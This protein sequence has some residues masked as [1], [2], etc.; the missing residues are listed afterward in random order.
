MTLLVAEGG[1]RGLAQPAKPKGTPVRP[2]MPSGPG[3]GPGVS[4][5]PTPRPS[6]SPS[7]PFPDA[8]APRHLSLPDPTPIVRRFDV[9]VAFQLTRTRTMGFGPSSIT[10]SYR[11]AWVLELNGSGMMNLRSRRASVPVFAAGP[12]T[13]SVI[14]TGMPRFLLISDRDV[15]RLVGILPPNQG[16]GANDDAD[17]AV[18]HM[19]TLSLGRGGRGG[20]DMTMG[21]TEEE[22]FA[23]HIDIGTNVVL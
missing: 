13:K 6:S 9:P 19:L 11:E 8:P 17:G 1:A 16:E 15:A 2:A 4:I 18:G 12:K 5:L 23:V 20:T 3:S 10:E 14:L 21:W 22:H 7:A